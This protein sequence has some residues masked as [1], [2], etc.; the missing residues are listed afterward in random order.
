MVFGAALTGAGVAHAATLSIS[1]GAVGQELEFCKTGAE[2]WAKKTGNQVNLISTPNSATERLALYQQLLAAGASDVDVFQIDVVWPGILGNHFLDLA[3]YA[4]D[5]V[6]NHFAAIVQNNTVDG[7]LV[8]M[9]W[10]TDAGLLYYRKDLLAKHGAQP[11]QTWQELTDTAKKI[12]D[13]ERAAGND[14]MWG[15]VW[16]G[17]AYE[18]LTCNALE[19]VS[20]YNGGTIVDDKGKITINN[21]KAIAALDTAAGWVKTISPEGVLNYTEEESRG[22]FQSGNAVFMRNWPYAWPLAQG[23]E[24]AIKDKVGVSALP[25]GGADGRHAATLGGWQLSV[26][27]Y[28]KNKELAADLVMYLTSAEEQKRRAIHGAY[29]PTIESLYKDAD[30]LKAVPFF[31]ELYDTFVNAVARPSTV[32]GAKY[33]QVSNEFWNAVHGVLSGRAKAQDSL[34]QLEASLK[35]MSRGGKW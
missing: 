9:P 16:Q 28:S 17:R 10:F 27:K 12:Q 13:A 21:P 19:W 14:K 6:K 1:C 11:P 23:P 2:A 7:K 20:S 33:N 31:G 30:V 25:R 34:A 26:S 22:V 4:K 8:A 32:T 18:G 35:R 3:P 15:F 24:S 29:N 5:V